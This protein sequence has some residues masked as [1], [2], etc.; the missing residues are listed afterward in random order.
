MENLKP[1]IQRE[2]LIIEGFYDVSLSQ[3]FLKN[4]L[5]GLSKTLDMKVIAGPY[6]FSPNSFSKLHHGLGG[7]MAWAESGVT[8]YSWGPHKFFTL[9]IY[10]CKAFDTKLA[11]EYVKKKLKCPRMVWERI[12]YDK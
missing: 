8:F 4:F 1:E 7:F 6:L 12:K 3:E 9:D 5:I 11:L 2:R 10:S